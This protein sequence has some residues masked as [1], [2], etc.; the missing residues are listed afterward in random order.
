ME[1][2]SLYRLNTAEH[3]PLH[4]E[5]A[6]LAN[7]TFAF[8]ID[9]VLM[10]TLMGL[11][12]LVFAAPPFTTVLKGLT[13]TLVPVLLFLLFF[14]LQMAQEWRMNGQSLGKLLFHIRVVRNNGQPIG[15]WEAFG[16]NVMRLIDVYFSGLGLVVMMC[17]PG[18]KRL[19]DYLAG[20]VVINDQPLAKPAVL[21]RAED[22]PEGPAVAVLMTPEEVELVRA[23][24][25]RRESLRPVPRRELAGA[26][27]A[28]LGE[29]LH[30]DLSGEEALA[31]LLAAYRQA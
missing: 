26:L 18:E 25:E 22:A 8:L 15:F 30:M 6:G 28:Y 4:V 17:S 31:G 1:F 29:R 16:R 9:L 3:V 24:L 14:G 12:L 23:F 5:L 19:G 7:R 27:C 11:V 13:R 2:R 10:L 21:G 20:T